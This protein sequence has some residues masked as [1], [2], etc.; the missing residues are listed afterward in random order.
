MKPPRTGAGAELALG[1]A[2]ENNKRASITPFKPR[3]GNCIACGQHIRPTG[4]EPVCATCRAW[5]SWYRAFEQS[6]RFL[7][8]AHK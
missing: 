5:W 8:A 1:G 4:A 3:I 2:A 7:R 6:S